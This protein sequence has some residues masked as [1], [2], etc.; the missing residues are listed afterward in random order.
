MPLMNMM[1]AAAEGASFDVSAIQPL[2]DTLTSQISPSVVV[3]ILALVVG[4]ATALALTWFGVRKVVSVIMTAFQK[5]K[6]RL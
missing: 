1:I 4:S 2:I 3:G 6:V 5:G